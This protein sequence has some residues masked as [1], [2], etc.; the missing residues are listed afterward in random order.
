[1]KKTVRQTKIEQLINQYV[2]STQEELM[3]RL[4]QAGIN[5]TQA[6]IS[7]DIREMQ[8]VKQQ[9]ASGSSRYMIYKAGNQNEMQHLYRSIGDTVTQ[10]DRVQ[11][12]NVIHTFPSYANMLAAILDDLDLPEVKGTLAGHDVIIIISADE[13]EAQKMY[14]L[15][16]KHM[17]ED[18]VE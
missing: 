16:I 18:L 6:T 5:A 8:I 4:R 12:L 17:N 3:E 9:D 1:M 14:D 15:F 11:F 13:I 2:I 7:R 10:V